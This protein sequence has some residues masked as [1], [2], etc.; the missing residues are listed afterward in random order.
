MEPAC[1]LEQLDWYKTWTNPHASHFSLLWNAEWPSGTNLTTRAI[2]P[3]DHPTI[4]YGETLAAADS[5]G[6]AE[7]DGL[8]LRAAHGT[9]QICFAA[10]S[11][12]VSSH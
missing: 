11:F 7:Y 6:T 8:I 2:G 5:S 12:S 4:I 3:S 1:Q 10:A 9:S